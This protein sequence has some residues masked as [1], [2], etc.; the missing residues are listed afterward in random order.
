[1]RRLYAAAVWAS[2]Y[3]K[4]HTAGE[5]FWGASPG[6]FFAVSLALGTLL[7][8]IPRRETACEAV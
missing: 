7:W 2:L 1:M 6:C 4:R 3:L 5:L 8:R